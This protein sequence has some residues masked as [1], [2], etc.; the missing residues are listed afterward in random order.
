MISV[1]GDPRGVCRGKR[2]VRKRERGGAG[3][4]ERKAEREGSSREMLMDAGVGV[5]G[6]G[7]DDWVAHF[8]DKTE[9]WQQKKGRVRQRSKETSHVA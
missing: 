8:G 5:W 9:R 6:G 1:N 4:G 2:G 7:G 3:G